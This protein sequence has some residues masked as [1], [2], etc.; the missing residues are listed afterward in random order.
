MPG[1]ILI[2]LFSGLVLYR[3]KNILFSILVHLT[4]N[5]LVF[6][7]P[8]LIINL[9]L[10]SENYFHLKVGW[11][12]IDLI[13]FLGLVS[14]LIGLPLFLKFNKRLKDEFNIPETSR[15]YS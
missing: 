3:S 9:G 14:I 2:G 4:Y 8:F 10:H 5:T 11:Y 13:D 1:A 7:L 6:V 12:T 15:S